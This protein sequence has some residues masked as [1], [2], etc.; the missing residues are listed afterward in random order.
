M[1]CD[2]AL[3]AEQRVSAGAAAG[4]AQ[5]ALAVLKR[6]QGLS[7]YSGVQILA[8]GLQVCKV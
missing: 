1:S 5:V 3:N 8:V 6:V 2:A 7:L 4:K